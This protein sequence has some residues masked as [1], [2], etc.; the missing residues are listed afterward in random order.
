MEK[1]FEQNNSNNLYLPKSSKLVNIII[2]LIFIIS[3]ILLSI[4][5][6]L[7]YQDLPGSPRKI[8]IPLNKKPEFDLQLK[9]VLQFY[10][11]MKFNHNNISFYI[12]DNCDNNK[13]SRIL[14]A[15]KT[16]TLEIKNL[17]F[18]ESLNNPDILITC[19]DNNIA[20]LDK[21]YFISGEGGAKEIV[22]TGIYNV[23]VNGIIYFY[24]ESLGSLNCDYP[25]L[26]L[27]ELMHVFGF[28]HSSDKK[29]IMYPYLESCEQT[30]DSS[31]AKKLN[32]LYS[33]Q[34]LPDIYFDNAEVIKKGRYIDFNITFKN[35][36]LANAKAINFSI[37]DENEIVETKKIGNINFGA[38]IIIEIKNFKLIRRNPKE[39]IFYID[40]E[41]K[42]EELD[43]KNNILKIK[44]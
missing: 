1:N 44:L 18:Y 42:I 9:P 19:S 8:D 27:H 14:L 26:E 37:I 11:N 33:I 40:S 4:T 16:L 22:Q 29:S 43:K 5:G 13:K 20:P 12:E 24:S 6:Y 23:I 17:S 7:L 30:L 21:D 39:I 28:N 32:E 38:G 31:I 41:N 35:S 34:N 36:G 15:L 2:F 25:N 3:L 10:D